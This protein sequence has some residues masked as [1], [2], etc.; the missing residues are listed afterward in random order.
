MPP[1]RLDCT[2]GRLVQTVVILTGA[3]VIWSVRYRIHAE[4]SCGAWPGFIGNDR[5]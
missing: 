4:R 5:L 2:T 3:S 1:V